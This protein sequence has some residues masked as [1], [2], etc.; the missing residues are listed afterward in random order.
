MQPS[1]ENYPSD[2]S[3]LVALLVSCSCSE[4]NHANNHST[5]VG[6]LDLSVQHIICLQLL[7]WIRREGVDGA[8]GY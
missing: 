7:H 6:C 8:D 5:V 2:L 1:Q 4:S 3:A